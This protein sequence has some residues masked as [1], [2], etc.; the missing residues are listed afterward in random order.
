MKPRI[1]KLLKS[2]QHPQ[3]FYQVYDAENGQVLVEKLFS[4]SG[5]L[6]S[7]EYIPED[8]IKHWTLKKQWNEWK[9]YKC[10]RRTTTPAK[11]MEEPMETKEKKEHKPT[12]SQVSHEK[13]V[14]M[15]S[16]QASFLNRK[17]RTIKPESLEST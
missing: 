17:R 13:R 14:A 12:K 4:V 1:V 2:R 9:V 3:I 5:V 11:P 6:I 16:R 7:Q 15:R 10:L 8:E